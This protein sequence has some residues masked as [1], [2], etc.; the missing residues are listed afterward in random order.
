[1]IVPLEEVN[2]VVIYATPEGGSALATL[3]LDLCRKVTQPDGTSHWQGVSGATGW[4]ITAGQGDGYDGWHP[5]S[6]PGL[7]VV[8]CGA[9]EIESSNGQRR[10]LDTGDVL[11]MLDTTGKGHRS[12]TLTAPCAVMGISFD[13]ATHARIAAQVANLATA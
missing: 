9:W 8:L 7:S 6:I 10:I 2:A 4:G 1:M 11:V 3:P 13:A 5:S 12:R